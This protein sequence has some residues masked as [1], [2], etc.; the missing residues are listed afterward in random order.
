MILGRTPRFTCAPVV[1]LRYNRPKADTSSLVRRRAS[2]QR[3]VSEEAKLLGLLPIAAVAVG[4][5]GRRCSRDGRL[6]VSTLPSSSCGPIFYKGSGSPQYLIASDLPLQG[7][8]RAQP[9]RWSRRS[10]TCWTSSSSSRPVRSGSATSRVTTRLR[11]RGWDDREVHG[12]RPRVRERQ[13]GAR[14][15]R[16]V[17]LRLR[18]ARDPDPEPCAGWPV[19]MISREHRGGADAHAPWNDPG[20]PN[21]YYPTGKPQLRPCRGVRRLPGPVRGG[22]AQEA[23]E[24]KSVYILHDNQTFG[25]GVANAFG[26]GRKARHQRRGLRAVGR[27]GRELRGD[28]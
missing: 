21:I 1:T 23:Q 19:A 10:S 9:R 15:A 26:R 4:L 6:R 11:S 8:G 13:V 16:D 25:K 3:R 7:A 14:R 20:E 27:E 2:A 24:V 17:Q 12:E 28:R 22:P 18:E 5:V